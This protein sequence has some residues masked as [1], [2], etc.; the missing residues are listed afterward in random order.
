MG[1]KYPL[2]GVRELEKLS[3][4]KASSFTSLIAL[5]D[6]QGNLEQEKQF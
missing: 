2:G 3:S 5:D 6:D 4:S 1:P